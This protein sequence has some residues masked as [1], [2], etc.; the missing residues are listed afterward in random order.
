MLERLERGTASDAA[1]TALFEAICDGRIAAGAPLRLQELS[2]QLG[3]SMMPIREA[4][5]RLAAMD[6]VELQPHK[7]AWVRTMSLQ[8]LRETYETRFVL[9][10]AATRAA[11]DHFTEHDAAVARRALDERAD[12]LAAGDR[13]ASRDAHERF[14]FTI[15]EAAG[16]AWLVRSIVPVWRN[17]ERYRVESLRHPEIA[18][19]RAAEHEEILAAVRRHDGDAAERS[20][21]E[22]LRSSMKIVEAR[23]DEDSAEQPGSQAGSS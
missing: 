3:L 17:S 15:Y 18:D 11:A 8:D 14:H 16:N 12:S 23:L 4:I 19:K 21:V 7:G 13:R 20:L 1:T 2:N 5:R 22:H 9:E 6:L 10:G